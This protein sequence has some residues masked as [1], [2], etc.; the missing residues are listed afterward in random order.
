MDMPHFIYPFISSFHFGAFINNNALWIF[1]YKF[2]CGHMFA[3]L[4][5]KPRSGTAQPWFS[6][7]VKSLLK[8][9]TVKPTSGCSWAVSK[10]FYQFSQTPFT[11]GHLARPLLL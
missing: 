3:F 4:L 10:E 7:A 11:V 2:L 5:G 8:S 6:H 9:F 1:V